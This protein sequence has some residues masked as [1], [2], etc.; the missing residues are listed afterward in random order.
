MAAPNNNA[1]GLAMFLGIGGQYTYGI[2]GQ[3]EPLSLANIDLGKLKLLLAT[4]IDGEAHL[5][6]GFRPIDQLLKSFLTLDD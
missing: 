1:V 3:Y 6:W 4:H 2:G 5:L